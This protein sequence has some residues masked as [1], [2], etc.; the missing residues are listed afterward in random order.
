MLLVANDDMI[1]SIWNF[2]SGSIGPIKTTTPHVTFED[3]SLGL[4]GGA[5]LGD[6]SHVITLDF[7]GFLYIWRISDGVRTA[8]LKIGDCDVRR[9]I[10]YRLLTITYLV[11]M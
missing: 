7:N 4:A 6:E 10:T 9:S 11:A 2:P 3:H 1:A 5:F 8:K